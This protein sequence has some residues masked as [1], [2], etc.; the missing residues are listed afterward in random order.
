M[1]KKYYWLKLKNDFFKRHDIRIISAMPNGNEYVLL[2]LKLMVESIDHEGN[3]R[4]SDKLPYTAEM[5][6]TITDTDVQMVTDALDALMK[7]G[8]VKQ[9]KDGT[10]FLPKVQEMIGTSEQDDHTREATRKRVRAFRER[11]KEHG[12][13]DCNNDETLPKRYSNVK[14]NGEIEKEIEIDIEKEIDK[15]FNNEV[16]NKTFS[17]FLRYRGVSTDIE[18]ERIK[19]KLVKLANCDEDLMIKILN[20][21][22]EN[23]WK[24]LFPIENRMSGGRKPIV[25]G[26]GGWE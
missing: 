10:Y 7:I 13:D 2:Y 12:N 14:C 19:S 15:E 17:D 9:K 8:L 11:Q 20:Q 3:L 21:S 16:L 5:L 26:Q 22:I 18:K 4:F 23:G 24:G 6:G 1:G 25:I